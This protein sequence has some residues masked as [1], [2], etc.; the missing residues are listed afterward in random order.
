M[1]LRW[2]PWGPIYGSE[3]AEAKPGPGEIQF[4]IILRDRQGKA[5]AVY[6][7]PPQKI[8]ILPR[9]PDA[10]KATPATGSRTSL[11]EIL[12]WKEFAFVGLCEAVEDTTAQPGPS[13]ISHAT[14]TF[15]ILDVLAGD[16]PKGKTVELAY[17]IIVF[18][19]PP[20]RLIAKGER[21]LWVVWKRGET[22]VGVKALADT[23]ENRKA[24]VDS[25]ASTGA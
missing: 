15:K 5:T 2:R 24:V 4:K 11:D 1:P 21:V 17:S 22:L 8:T 3:E 18:R 14:Q 12:K 7:L 16:G 6:D 25:A 10:N 19:P 9:R 20:E 23:P 13:G